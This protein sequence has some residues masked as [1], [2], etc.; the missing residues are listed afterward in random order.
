MRRAQRIFPSRSASMRGARAA[1]STREVMADQHLPWF[2]YYPDNMLA[3]TGLKAC[4]LAA[5]GLWHRLCCMMHS[6]QPYGH[7]VVANRRLTLADW[8]TIALQVGADPKEVK[9][10]LIELGEASVFSI[11]DDGCIY[12]RRMV[13]DEQKR[14]QSRENGRKGGNPNLKTLSD[15]RRRSEAPSR[16]DRLG[17]DGM[18]IA[19]NNGA[20]N[21]G[22]NPLDKA[23]ARVL[24]PEPKPETRAGSSGDGGPPSAAAVPPG[25]NY[26]E[27]I[28]AVT[29][30][31]R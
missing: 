7:L 31:R 16:Y 3:D 13:R 8:K 5:Q 23:H 25:R 17:P 22:V 2:P 11:A 20:V 21:A 15:P 4:S 10:C 14:V 18:V 28:A 9:K 30:Q 19:R 6:A 26:S 12:S 24:E 29:G 1:A 27:M